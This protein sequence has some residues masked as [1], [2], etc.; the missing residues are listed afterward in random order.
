MRKV[1]Y[2]R[3]NY[4]DC[5]LFFNGWGM[6]QHILFGMD[7]PEM[8]VCTFFDYTSLE[9]NS[10]EFQSY[11]NLYCV[12][13]SMGVWAVSNIDWKGMQFAHAIAI[14]GT[15]RPRDD[16][17][18][19]PISIFDGTLENWSG[20]TREKF[21][22]RSIGNRKNIEVVDDC[23]SLRSTTD[24]KTE[25]KSISARIQAES[26]KNQ[27]KWDKV[28]C[29]KNDKIIPFENQRN[30]WSNFEALETVEL[31]IPHYPFIGLN[32]WQEIL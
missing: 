22:I 2:H 6:D 10:E 16:K 30:F 25:L 24:Q 5:I 12:A 29:G 4:Q 8:D 17:N 27:I 23:R 11:R 18:G 20:V 1:W 14:N 15:E 26:I 3:K 31:D 21:W 7:V 19:I 9:W 32:S 28:F 13:W